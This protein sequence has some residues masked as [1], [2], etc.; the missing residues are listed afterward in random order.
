MASVDETLVFDFASTPILTRSYASA[1]RLAIYCNVSNPP[2]G[3]RWV[4]QAPNDCS[5]AI[6]FA[7]KRRIEEALSAQS[8]QREGYL[9]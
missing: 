8:A 6:Q 4:Q 2:H 7:R 5:G 3:L 9:H 1:M